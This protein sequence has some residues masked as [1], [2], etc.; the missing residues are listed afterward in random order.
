MA[1][2]CMLQHDTQRGCTP[3]EASP[4]AMSGLSSRFHRDGSLPGFTILEIVVATGIFSLI[5]VAAIGITLAAAQAQRKAANLQTVQ[6]SARFGLELMT[7]ELRTGSAYTPSA[8][9]GITGQELSFLTFSGAVRVYYKSGNTLMRLV[10]TTNCAAAIPLIGNDVIVDLV[11][12]RIGGQ[13]PGGLDGQPWVS[14]SLSVRSADPKQS[15]E[16]RMDIQTTVVERL[17]DL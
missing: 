14:I 8:F 17:R 9:C 11:R 3:L 15:L 4:D 13:N 6:D 5:A 2:H 16:S 1:H 12:F 7:K 10:G